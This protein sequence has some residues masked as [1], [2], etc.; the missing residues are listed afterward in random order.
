MGSQSP[1][2]PPLRTRCSTQIV[3]ETNGGVSNYNALTVA[4]TKRMSKGLQFQVSYNFAKNLS[5][6]GGYNPGAFAG[7]G[8]GQTSDYFN[9]DRWIMGTLRLPAGSAS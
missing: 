9:P 3:E 6:N 4:V 1:P 8:G 5:D 7:S 2:E